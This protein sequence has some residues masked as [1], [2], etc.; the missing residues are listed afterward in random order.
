L[1][2]GLGFRFWFG[3]RFWFWFGFWL[4][5]SNRTISCEK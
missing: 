2:L 5:L 1:W 3:L 4:W